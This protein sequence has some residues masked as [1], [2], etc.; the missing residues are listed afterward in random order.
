MYINGF[1]GKMGEMGVDMGNGFQGLCL[2]HDGMYRKGVWGICV[3]RKANVK[4]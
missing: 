3:A 2:G 4:V 1:M